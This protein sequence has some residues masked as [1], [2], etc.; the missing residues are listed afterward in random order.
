MQ[1]QL[2][3]DILKI[4]LNFIDNASNK[5]IK[6]DT[7]VRIL[8]TSHVLYQVFD[9]NDVPLNKFIID[10][11]NNDKL[12]LVTYKDIRKNARKKHAQDDK[13]DDSI[14]NQDKMNQEMELKKPFQSKTS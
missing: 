13:N 14:V 6:N 4:M 11:V 5:N 9:L 1:C 12:S 3:K 7:I 10:T 2:V 8:A